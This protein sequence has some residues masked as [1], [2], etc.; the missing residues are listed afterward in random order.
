MTFAEL[1]FIFLTLILI[2]FLLRPLQ[3]RLQIY[4]HN[5]F[6]KKKRSNGETIDVTPIKKKDTTNE[7]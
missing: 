5:F 2:S 6:Q 7:Q 3:R 4:F 1:A